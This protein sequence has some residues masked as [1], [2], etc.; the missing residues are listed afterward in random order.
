MLIAYPHLSIPPVFVNLDGSI[1][2]RESSNIQSASGG[3]RYALNPYTYPA[4][5]YLLGGY[6]Y[7]DLD[8]TL[9]IT[10]STNPGRGPFP[11]GRVD[12]FDNFAVTNVFNGGEIG[13]GTELGASRLSLIADTRLAMGNM[14]ETLNIDGRTSAIS[15]GFVASYA[16]GLLAQPTNIGSYSRDVFVL[17]PQ[18]DLKLAYQLLPP[19]R[20]TVGYNFTYVTRVLRPGDQVDTT[21]NTTQVAGGALVGPASPHAPFSDTGLWLQGVTAGLDLRF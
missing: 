11:P 18:V 14:H 1:N 15:G 7:F 2:V 21:V 3:G 9:T 8:E 19:L 6:R 13:L 10:T 4:R 20:V 16:G 12:S 17:I 5:F